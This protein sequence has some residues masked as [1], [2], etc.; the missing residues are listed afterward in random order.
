MQLPR[1][2]GPLSERLFA[3]LGSD[4][5][6]EVP[7]PVSEDVLADEDVQIALW[8]LYELAYRGFDDVD[9]AHEWSPAMLSTRATL[10]AA[11]ET[12]LRTLAAPA[13][14]AAVEQPER[15]AAQVLAVIEDVEDDPGLAQ[16]LQRHATEEQYREFLVQRS[17]YHLKESDPHAWVLPRLDGAPKGRKEQGYWVRRQDEYGKG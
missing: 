2:R 7:A 1:P 6:V 10:E 5:P 8:A 16:Y 4:V 14:E 15:V 12:A 13:V 11:F 9:P 3:Q 17:V